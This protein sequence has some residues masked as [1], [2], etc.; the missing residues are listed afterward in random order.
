MID[1]SFCGGVFDVEGKQKRVQEL[2]QI[3]SQPDFWNDSDK[4]QV[5]LKEQSA[6][7]A[8]IGAWEKHRADL[9]EARFYIDIAQEE[10]SDEALG[11]AAAKIATGRQ[12]AGADRADPAAR[13][14][15]RPEKRDRHAPSRRRRHRGAGLGGDF[16][17]V[18]SALVRPARL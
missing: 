12:R 4:A 14:A 16:I 1:S 2:T 6:L 7:K 15:R 13:R 18:V 11:E 9:E 10:K 8:V 17:A 3:T 5:V